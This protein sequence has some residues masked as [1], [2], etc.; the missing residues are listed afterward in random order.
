MK[1]FS[2]FISACSSALGGLAEACCPAFAKAIPQHSTIASTTH[3]GFIDVPPINNERRRGTISIL[4]NLPSQ[5]PASDRHLLSGREILQR[6]CVG[7]HL[8]LADDQ[9]VRRSRSSRGL[10]RF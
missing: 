4:T 6:K 8:V 1:P 5:L 9:D 10:K 3:A 7:L 2:A